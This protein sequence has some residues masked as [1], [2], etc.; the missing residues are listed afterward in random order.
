MC[1]VNEE[2]KEESDEEMLGVSFCSFLYLF[3]CATALCEYDL[4]NR[5][6]VTGTFP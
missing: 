5:V 3:L 4:S 6:D 2:E 1:G